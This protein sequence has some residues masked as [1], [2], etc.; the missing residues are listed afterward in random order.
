MTASI[1]E[2]PKLRAAAEELR[3]G[4]VKVGDAVGEALKSMEESELVRV[5]RIIR[6]VLFTHT[7]A[8]NA[9]ISDFSRIGSGV[10]HDR[11][12]HGTYPEHNSIQIVDSDD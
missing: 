2:N 10:E 1:K 5:V 6:Y 12:N 7:A 4:G 3:K 8:Y 11:E 9:C